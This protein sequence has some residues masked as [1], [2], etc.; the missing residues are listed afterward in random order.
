MR[1]AIKI[2]QASA[3]V[4]TDLKERKWGGSPKKQTLSFC[5]RT[6]ECFRNSKSV[7]GGVQRRLKM[8]DCWKLLREAVR[9]QVPPLK[10]TDQCLPLPW[11]RQKPGSLLSWGLKQKVLEFG[12]QAQLGRGWRLRAA[13]PASREAKSDLNTEGDSLPSAYIP[14]RL[15]RHSQSCSSHQTGGWRVWVIRQTRVDPIVRWVPCSATCR[16]A[17]QTTSCYLTALSKLPRAAF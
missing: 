4:V 8:G 16:E 12:T 1:E 6:L 2:L 13:A 11:W 17:H 7:K 9:P 10:L 5:C 3:Q 14:V 15:P